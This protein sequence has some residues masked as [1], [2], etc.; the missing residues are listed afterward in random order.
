[1]FCRIS[2]NEDIYGLQWSPSGQ[3]L[4]VGLTDNTC[5]IFDYH[6]GNFVSQDSFFLF[7]MFCFLGKV[8]KTL[9]DH[10]HFVQ[11][12]AWDPLDACLA[13]QSSDRYAHSY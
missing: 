8:V 7:F 5:V 3:F 11:G 2:D 1:M 10:D 13:S 12:V 6:I 9:K 4:M